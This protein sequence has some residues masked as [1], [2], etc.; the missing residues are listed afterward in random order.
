MYQTIRKQF[1]W[2]GLM[3][4]SYHAVRACSA[5]EREK[6]KLQSNSTIM[7]LFPPSRLLEGIAMDLLSHLWPTDRGHTQI[8]VIV[9]RFTKMVRA[10][11]FKTVSAFDLARAF[12]RHWEFAYGIP[13]TVLTDSGKQFNLN[14]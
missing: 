9:D 4:S 14:F 8:L 6:I 11:P 13:K 3:L 10:V 7:K 1:Y 2:P 5:C 12:T